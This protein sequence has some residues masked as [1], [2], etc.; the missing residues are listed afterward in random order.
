MDFHSARQSACGASRSSSSRRF[1]KRCLTASMHCFSHTYAWYCR[2]SRSPQRGVM[3]CSTGAQLTATRS[4]W[5]RCIVA[6][7][8]RRV[9]KVTEPSWRADAEWKTEDSTV[10]TSTR[11][12]MLFTCILVT[13]SGQWRC[14][15]G[16]GEWG[17]L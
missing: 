14:V 10:R 2:C 3:V 8:P 6:F 12:E 17:L 13:P 4:S 5:N 9:G 15:R 11:K 7:S 1:R 16:N